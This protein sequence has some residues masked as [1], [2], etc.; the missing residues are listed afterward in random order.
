MAGDALYGNN[1]ELRSRLHARGMHYVL[2]V[3]KNHTVTTSDDQTDLAD[4]LIAAL[5]GRAWRTR[6][7]GNGTKGDRRYS[8]ARIR[9]TDATDNGQHWLLAR[10]NLADP[11]DLAYYR[12]YT[13]A[14]VTLVELARVAGG[15]WAI[16]ETSQTS[17]GENGLDHYQVRQY[18]GWYRHITLSMFAHAFLTVIR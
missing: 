4:A 6:T 10:R 3:S 8:W 1:T 14:N 15:R 7:A 16:E 11:T 2:A 12:C 17:K 18:T 9:I 5:D 13:P